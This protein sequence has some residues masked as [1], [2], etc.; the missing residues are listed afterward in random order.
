MV[1]LYRAFVQGALHSLVDP[2]HPFT[3][4]WRRK[5][6]KVPASHQEQ[7]GVKRLAQ[8]HSDTNS[9]GACVLTGNPACS[10]QPVTLPLSP[11][12]TQDTT[13]KKKSVIKV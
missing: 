7:L 6:C 11:I 13:Y 2:T 10:Y 5:P 3:H 8:G 4:Q 12:G 9:G 1:H